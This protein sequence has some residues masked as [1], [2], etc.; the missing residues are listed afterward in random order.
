MTSLCVDTAIR[1]MS[2]KPKVAVIGHSFI[3]WLDKDI[4]NVHLT[5]L[6]WNFGLAQC[7]VKICWS[8]GWEVLDGDRFNSVIAPFLEDF[9]PD[10][11]IIQIGGNDIDGEVQSITVSSELEALATRS[12]NRFGITHV[13]I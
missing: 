7:K 6:Q 12:L 9:S 13:F 4:R 3:K 2:C 8:S 1:L 5:Y 10:I 11:A